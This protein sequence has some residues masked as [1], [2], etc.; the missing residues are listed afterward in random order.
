MERFSELFDQLAAYETSPNTVHYVTC[1]T[2]GLKPSIR[3][4]LG[5][6]QPVDLDTAYQL[7]ILHEELG[8]SSIGS[9][10]SSSSRRSTALHSHLLHFR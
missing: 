9:T 10:G 7:A 5:I 6:Q 4:A 1:F 2:E 3:L 8:A